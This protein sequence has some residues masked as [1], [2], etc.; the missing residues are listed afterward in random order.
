MSRVRLR[1]PG[2]LE[3]HAQPQHPEQA[4]HPFP[5][6]RVALRGVPAYVVH[7][8]S[9]GTA[10]TGDGTNAVTGGCRAHTGR[11]KPVALADQDR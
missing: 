2:A 10:G 11:P 6:D 5:R 9:Y 4:A 3:D 1:R 7:K 8:G